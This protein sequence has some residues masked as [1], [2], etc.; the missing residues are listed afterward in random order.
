MTIRMMGQA[1]AAMKALQH[2]LDTIGHNLANSNTHGY[3]AR[4]VEFQSL[5]KQNI[6]N[7][8]DPNNARGRIT[9]N[10][11]RVG[12]GAKV[13]TTNSNLALGAMQVTGRNLDT[14]LLHENHFYQIR[15]QQ[16][17]VDEIRY[18]RNGAFYVTP[19]GNGQ[20]ELVTSDGYPVYGVNGP[21]RFNDHFDAIRI[22]ERG[23]VIVTY[24]TTDVVAG[25]LAIVEI[26]RPRLLEA[27]GDN[28]FRLPDLA[29]LGYNLDEIVRMAPGDVPLVKN[30]ALETSNV[31]IQEE[32]TDMINTQRAY[33][34]NARAITT[35]DQMQGLINQL[36]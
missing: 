10:G 15:V 36:R 29:A 6:N 20:V 5:L 2:K 22:N 32:M 31:S 34:L 7:L 9:P 17:G 18:T 27:V 1:S 26:V 3:K 14:M 8:S 28:A 25:R 11:I 12:T 35:A 23:E 33:Q 24:G 4:K 16:D 21:I 13:G 19:L 30:Q